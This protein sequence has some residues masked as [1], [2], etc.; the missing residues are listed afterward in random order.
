MIVTSFK[1]QIFSYIIIGGFTSFPIKLPRY[2]E[3]KWVMIEVCRQLIDVNMICQERRRVTI[4]FPIGFSPYTCQSM[5]D[6]LNIERELSKYNLHSYDEHFPF[7]LKDYVKNNLKLGPNFFHQPSMED[8]LA[9]YFDENE[10]KKRSWMRLCIEQIIIY[11]LGWDFQGIIEDG[12]DMVDLV[13]IELIENHPIPAL[14]WSNKEKETIESRTTDVLVRTQEW[15]TKK[16]TYQSYRLTRSQNTQPSRSTTQFS[17]NVRTNS[18][19]S[20][21]FPSGT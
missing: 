9:N 21:S 7:D 16:R 2:P 13:Y 19:T 11:G 4:C 12:S 15:M 18:T 5:F 20:Q 10:V 6:A 1:F 8:Y 14:D 3:D 17:P